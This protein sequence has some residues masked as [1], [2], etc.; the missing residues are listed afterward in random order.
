[1]LFVIALLGSN[2]LWKVCIHGD[3]EGQG[4][5]TCCGQI[6][7]PVFDAVA[8]H[9]TDAVFAFCNHVQD[10][11][12]RRGTT[13]SWDTGNRTRI[14]WSCTPIKQMF[15]W[16]FLIAGCLPLLSW[17]KLW[18]IP[19]GWLAIYGI[20][21]LRIAAITLIIRL[22]PEQFELWHTY[23]FKYLFYGLMF[24]GWAIYN[25]KGAQ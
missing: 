4:D 12:S 19:A 17:H 22:H 25:E 8:E 11:L 20:N 21:I 9:T 18:Y 3:E 16:F 23:I 1:M 13:L 24:A 7:T 2:A 15:I 10:G 6:V 14:V 5:V